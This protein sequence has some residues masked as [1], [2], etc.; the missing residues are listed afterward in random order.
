MKKFNAARI[1]KYFS[2]TLISLLALVPFYVVVL[3]SLNTPA[4]IFYEGNIL[5][6]DFHF[7]NYLD[8]WKS[9][10]IGIAMVNSI[11]I[12]GGALAVVVFFASSAGYTIARFKSR[13]NSIVF[14][15]FLMSMMIPGIINTVPL[16]ILIKSIGG[17][18]HLWAMILVCATLALPFSV[19]L[20]TG[21]IKSLSREIEE[22]AIIDGCS[23]F[24]AFWRVTFHFL[25]PVTAAVIIINGLSVWNNYAQAVF[26]LPNQKAHTI[27]LALSVFFQQF[28][29][30]KWNL[31]A[32][33]AVTGVFPVVLAFLVF[34]KSFMKGITAGALKG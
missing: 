8:A 16:Y 31:L 1:G 2:A 21:F 32:A 6:P 19:F 34:Q 33:A 12:A 27:P 26:F 7:H 30:A 28:A 10:K 13:F 23:W 24:S 25:K 17:I 15:I 9:S 5:L 14:S 4:R 11:I 22:S 18:N 29:G 3:F 20:Y